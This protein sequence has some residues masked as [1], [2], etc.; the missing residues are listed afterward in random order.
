[1]ADCCVL[2]IEILQSR[3]RAI[4]TWRDTFP[5]ADEQTSFPPLRPLDDGQ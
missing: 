4:P 1:M 2:S 3:S 5:S